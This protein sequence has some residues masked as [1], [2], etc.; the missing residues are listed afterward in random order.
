MKIIIFGG[1][2]TIGKGDP[3]DGGW[4]GRLRSRIEENDE[5]DTVFILGIPG[6]TT[7]GMRKRVSGEM[8]A[9]GISSDDVCLVAVGMN[10]SRKREDGDNEIPLKDFTVNMKYILSC[11][12]KR[13]EKILII[14]PSK[15]DE[16]R[17]T[18]FRGNYYLNEE[19]MRYSRTLQKICDENKIPFIDMTQ[20]S[21]TPS[22]LKDGL[23]PVPSEHK[24][25]FSLIYPKVKEMM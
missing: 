19:I 13:T 24:N 14:G 12:R 1:S 25:R 15:V 11:I 18:P 7:Q 8:D 9:R 6:E 4:A 10:D 21:P 2:T 20:K 17:T 5:R 22:R 23:H 3:K 16:K